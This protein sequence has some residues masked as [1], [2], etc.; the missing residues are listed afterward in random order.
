MYNLVEENSILRLGIEVRK[1]VEKGWKPL[2]G[3]TNGT[4]D[5]QHKW[6][7]AMWMDT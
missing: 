2:G 1:L 4:D 7:Q 3:P 5:M 6:V